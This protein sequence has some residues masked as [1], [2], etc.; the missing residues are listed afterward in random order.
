MTIIAAPPTTTLPGQLDPAML[1]ELRALAAAHCDS[2]GGCH[3]PDHGVRVERSALAMARQMG[4]RADILAPAAI[5]HDIGRQAE[6]ASRGQICHAEQGA[7]MA[8]AILADFGLAPALIEMICRAIRCHRFRGTNI[9]VSLEEKIL[10]DADKL[11]S[12]GA[13]GIGRAF[14]FAG[15]IGARLH[16]ENN[17]AS[18]TKAYSMDDTAFREFTVKLSKVKERM[19]TPL[20][21][22]L[23]Q[24]RHDFMTIFFKRLQGEMDI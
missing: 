21:Q 1:G 5:L 14:L 11:D 3:G 20:G 2:Q 6:T 15:Q 4:G 9:P 18:G 22:Q 8:A 19:L 16:N 17:D 24:E 10:F 12:I 23:A 13:I 7:E